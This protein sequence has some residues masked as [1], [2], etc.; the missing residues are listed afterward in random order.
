MRVTTSFKVTV[1]RKKVPKPV[2]VGDLIY[3]GNE[4]SA[5]AWQNYNS[6]YM[7]ISGEISGIN[8]GKYTVTFT[9]KDNYCWNDE[10][11]ESIDVEWEIKK[12]QGRVIVDPD[13]ITLD[14]ENP[15]ATV[16]LTIIGSGMLD[17]YTQDPS[18]AK[19]SSSSDTEIVVIKGDDPGDRSTTIHIELIGGMNYF[20]DSKEIIVNADFSSFDLLVTEDRDV[21]TFGDIAI[22]LNKEG[23]DG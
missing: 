5:D 7:I 1:E 9:L 20:G 17:I 16:K 3:N 19:I 22:I 6:N 11:I 10:S 15:T 13:T 2:W 14:D 21:I 12:A 23:Q 18:V 8:A 4:Q